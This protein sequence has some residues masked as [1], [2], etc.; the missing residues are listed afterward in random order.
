MAGVPM[1]GFGSWLKDAGLLMAD[2]MMS[3]WGGKNI[4]KDSAYSNK[5]MSKTSGVTNKFIEVGT[6]IAAGM[7]APGIG[8]Q[9][10]NGVQSNIGSAVGA[11]NSIENSKISPEQMLLNNQQVL[12][13]LP[14][15]QQYSY[16]DG[17]KIKSNLIGEVIVKAPELV[18]Q[19]HNPFFKVK[20]LW[21]TEYKTNPNAIIGTLDPLD[22]NFDRGITLQEAMQTLPKGMRDEYNM[23][24][25]YHSIN[26]V[27]KQFS[28][29]E[30]LNSYAVGGPINDRISSFDTGGLHSENGGIPIGQNALVE[31]G[32]F[33]Y[34]TKG[35]KKYIFTNKF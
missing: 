14:T 5:I 2:N 12:N 1:Y 32:E 25:F 16:G 33:M 21:A 6:G 13:S 4:I 3:T 24:A 31:R 8:S 20:P 26:P 10:V 27:Q 30:L 18:K 9:L 22:Q 15:H 29:G 23:D 28:D 11:D 7:L 17:G 19:T 34:T 35:G